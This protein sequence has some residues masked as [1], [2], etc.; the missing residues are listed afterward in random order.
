MPSPVAA[1]PGA[2]AADDLDD[3]VKHAGWPGEDATGLFICTNLV[4]ARAAS[5]TAPSADANVARPSGGP[6][7][8]GTGRKPRRAIIMLR[9]PSETMA[10]PCVRPTIFR[11]G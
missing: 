2:A 4:D 5:E 10:A 9:I 11:V 1:S 3:H 6:A 8:V 7:V